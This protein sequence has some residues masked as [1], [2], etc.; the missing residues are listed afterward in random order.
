MLPEE[1]SEALGVSLSEVLV[2]YYSGSDVVERGRLIEDALG[3][4]RSEEEGDEWL[5]EEARKR[6]AVAELVHRGGDDTY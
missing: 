4:K 1:L 6:D 2:R 5:A 3:R